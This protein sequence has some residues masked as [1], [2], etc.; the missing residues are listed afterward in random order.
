MEAVVYEH[1]DVVQV[2]GG[3]VFHTPGGVLESCQTDVEVDLIQ[4]S[5]VKRVELARTI[6]KKNKLLQNKKQ[7]LT[8]FLRFTSSL[9][10]VLLGINMD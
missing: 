10:K 5:T 7:V 4:V 6:K 8:E 2:Q 1:A 3:H 9:M